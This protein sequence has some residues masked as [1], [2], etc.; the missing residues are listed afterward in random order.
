MIGG[1]EIIFKHFYEYKYKANY[2]IIIQNQ[3]R[4]QT[5]M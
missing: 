4:L 2:K 5:I 1:Y 3:V